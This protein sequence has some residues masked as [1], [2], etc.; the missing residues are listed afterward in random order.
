[1]YVRYQSK[2]TR[3]YTTEVYSR[4]GKRFNV[5]RTF[6]VRNWWKRWKS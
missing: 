5:F 2:M 4:W 6:Y 1:M 3:H